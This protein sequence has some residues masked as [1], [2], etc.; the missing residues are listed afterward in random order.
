MGWGPL[1]HGGTHSAPGPPLGPQGGPAHARQGCVP[2]TAR[3]G[4]SVPCLC[5]RA[6]PHTRGTVHCVR[7]AHTREG[8]G[9]PWWEMHRRAHP[10]ALS[11]AQEE[12][13]PGRP[14]PHPTTPIPDP[15]ECQPSPHPPQASASLAATQHPAESPHH[16]APGSHG[17]PETKVP[18]LPLSC[19]QAQKG[20]TWGPRSQAPEVQQD[21][22]APEG[23]AGPGPHL[24]RVYDS[25]GLLSRR[26]VATR[27]RRGQLGNRAGRALWEGSASQL[28]LAGSQVAAT[29][30]PAAGRGHCVCGAR[31]QA[32]GNGGGGDGGEE[33]GR[34]A[35]GQHRDSPHTYRR[36]L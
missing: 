13:G 17:H 33:A 21:L 10:E 9:M 1:S 36:L 19:P 25:L 22:G 11:R 4:A 26:A 7:G 5:S 27:G 2:V 12:S 24:H 16:G 20:Q 28:A 23:A 15:G 29:G 14:E 32:E 34:E 8:M 6:R 35:G 3:T 31:A 30:V 18:A